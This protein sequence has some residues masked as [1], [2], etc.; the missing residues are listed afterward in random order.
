MHDAFREC[1]LIGYIWKWSQR[2]GIADAVVRETRRG[3]DLGEPHIPT[4]S[5]GF[6]F[7]EAKGWQ[8]FA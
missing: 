3:S 1:K 7:K 6:I 2:W 5:V 8:S 4:A